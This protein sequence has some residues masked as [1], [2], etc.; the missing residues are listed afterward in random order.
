MRRL[1]NVICWLG[2][3]LSGAG[4]TSIIVATRV[5]GHDANSPHADWYNSAEIMPEAQKRL[6]FVKCC[7]GDDIVHSQ[8]RVD[9]TTGGDEWYYKKGG[10]WTRIPDDI[11]HWGEY[12]PNGE[13]TLFALLTPVAGNPVGTLTCFYPPREGI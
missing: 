3:F 1:T 9:K 12:A 4:I 5:H 7:S 6:R 10:A 11:I 2:I 8:F 13:P